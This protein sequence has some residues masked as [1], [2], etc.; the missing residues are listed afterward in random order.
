MHG[1]MEVLR[2]FRNIDVILDMMPP[3]NPIELL[4]NK[5]TEDS[6]HEDINVGLLHVVGEEEISNDTPSSNNK[7]FFEFLRY[8]SEELY[9]GSKYSKLEFLLKLY[10]TKCSS[11]LSDK[12]MTMLL[13]LLRDAFEFARIPN[14]FYEAK[15]TIKKFSLHYI[16]IDACPNNCMLYWGDDINEET[17]KHCHLSRWK[18]HKKNINNQPA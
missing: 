14:S 8:G 17:C 12:G 10:H 13:D 3:K 6:I 2:N 18:P 5:A 7:D 9:E 15:K 4:I 11:G 16:K 1:E